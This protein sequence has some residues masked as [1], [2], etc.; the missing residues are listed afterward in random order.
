MTALTLTMLTPA[1]CLVKHP[2]GRSVGLTSTLHI[3]HI[4]RC[5]VREIPVETCTIPAILTSIRDQIK[6]GILLET[7]ESCERNVFYHITEEAEDD[8]G[9]TCSYS[10]HS[11][12]APVILPQ[13]Q[14]V[15]VL[16]LSYKWKNNTDFDVS[17]FIDNWGLLRWNVLNQ[18]FFFNY[19]NFQWSRKLAGISAAAE[20][21]SW[22]GQ[23]SQGVNADW[24]ENVDQQRPNL[25]YSYWGFSSTRRS[26]VSIGLCSA[27]KVQGKSWYKRNLTG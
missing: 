17:H 14:E 11:Y 19:S 22:W 27:Y 18:L 1:L 10:E 25:P 12:F 26:P 4:R 23:I 3:I 15:S 2:P 16:V 5:I 21:S 7:L 13:L 24:G 6:T 20:I 8:G 9:Q